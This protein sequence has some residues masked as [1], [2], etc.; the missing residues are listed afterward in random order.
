MYLFQES[1]GKW[2]FGKTIDSECGAGIYRVEPSEDRSSLTLHSIVNDAIIWKDRAVTS[3]KKSNGE[4]YSGFL[5]LQEAYSGFFQTTQAALTVVG[6]LTDTQLR[7]TP[8]PV[9]PVPPNVGVC[10]G[11]VA[12]ALSDTVDLAHPG[13]IQPRLL[14]GNIKVTDVNGN[15]ITLAFD[16]KEISLFRVKRVWSTG[17]TANMGIVVI[18]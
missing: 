18:Y 5:E 4:A 8:V 13:Y 16:A 15:V 6:G 10:D 9:S 17:T 11:C 2:I 7:A 3:F 14:P 12:A 1:P